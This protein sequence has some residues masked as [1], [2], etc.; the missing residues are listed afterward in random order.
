MWKCKICSGQ[1]ETIPDGAILV[2]K[3]GS[4]STY[5]FVDGAIHCLYTARPSAS[6]NQWRRKQKRIDCPL[7][8]PPQPTPEPQPEPTP[9][10]VVQTELQTVEVADLPE[11]QPEPELELEIT[12]EVEPT[13]TMAA[14]F[15]R[16]FKS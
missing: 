15:H 5:R 8:Y 3:R 13:T 6:H 1:F 7:C 10:P 11:P 2:S 14:A 9:T 4:V 12:E 16:L